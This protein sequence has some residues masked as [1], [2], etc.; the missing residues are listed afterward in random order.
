M[1]EKDKGFSFRSLFFRDAQTPA[2]AT[3]API[4]ETPVYTPPPQGTFMTSPSAGPMG[5]IPEQSLVEDFVQRLQNLINQ[6]NQPGFDFLEFTESLFEEKQ[7]PGPEVYK[8]VFRIAQKIDKTLTP[9]KLLQ[10]A[11]YYKDLVQKTAEGEIAKG[12]SKKQGLEVEKNTE[13]TNLDA[14][15]KEMSVKIQQ[16]TRQIQELQN[17]ELSMNNQLMAIDQKY[18]SQFIDIERKI[19]AIRNAKE[20]VLVSIVDIEAGI[21]TN[22]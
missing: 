5:G 2:G 10:S 17:Q 11:M 18:A 12:E 9:S 4:Q 14:S 1:A 21:K 19:N 3:A 15:L 7:N 16:L 13:R 20:Q 6:N 8:T 22:L